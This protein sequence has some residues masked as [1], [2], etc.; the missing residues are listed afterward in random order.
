ME[1]IGSSN[2]EKLTRFDTIRLSK[3]L[4]QVQFSV[5]AF[6]ITFFLGIYADKLFPVKEDSTSEF[7]LWRDTLLQLAVITIGAYYVIKISKV[8]PFLFSLDNRYIAGSHGE[9]VFGAGLAMSII[10]VSVQ[11]NFGA[12]ISKLKALYN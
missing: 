9:N 12:R 2:L 7:D 5:I 10:F 3:L 4:E 11:K 6:I 8:I 1:K